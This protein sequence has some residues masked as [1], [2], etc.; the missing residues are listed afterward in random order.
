MPEKPDQRSAKA[1]GGGPL[2]THDVFV[3]YTQEDRDIDRTIARRLNERGISTWLDIERLHPGENWSE[4]LR[5]AVD[6][7]RI[8]VVLL[9]AKTN[10]SAALVSKEWAAM[11]ECAWRRP[12]FSLCPVL[13]DNVT[14]PAFLRGWQGLRL[15]RKA[16]D[17]EE[18]VEKIV[19]IVR[20][21][22]SERVRKPSEQDLSQA[23]ARFTEIARTLEEVKKAD[24]QQ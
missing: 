18:G 9:S 4:S 19:D 14:I 1:R 12:E 21:D 22:P 23:A 16:E 7:S 5:Q 10:P 11:Q 6:A 3:S 13:L 24:D 8:G 17:I 20:R 15:S 2:A